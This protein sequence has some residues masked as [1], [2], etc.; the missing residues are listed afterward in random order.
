MKAQVF[1]KAR[2]MYRVLF[3]ELLKK[4]KFYAFAR[5]AFDP[6]YRADI[7]HLRNLLSAPGIKMYRAEMRL[8]DIK[9]SHDVNYPEWVESLKGRLLKGERPEPIKV[10]WDHTRNQWIVIDGNHRLAA[11]R[12]VLSPDALVRV[13]ILHRVGDLIHLQ[14][15]LPKLTERQL[16]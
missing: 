5:L 3:H 8:Q 13:K 1:Y 15:V 9:F 4:R 7:L 16:S 10:F 6:V 14:V 11:M 2:W 12:A